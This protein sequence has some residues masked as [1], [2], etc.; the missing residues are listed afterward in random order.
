M[1]LPMGRPSAGLVALALA[2]S[3]VACDAGDLPL[4][5]FEGPTDVAILAAGSNFDVTIGFVSNARSGD[6]VKLDLTNQRWLA[7]T[8][9]GPLFRG[10]P[11]A[12]GRTRLLEQVAV[13]SNDDLPNGGG[14][15]FITLFAS[16]SI[17]Q[18]LLV[19]P[20]LD[21][22]AQVAPSTFCLN[23]PAAEP[24][25]PRQPVC[26]TY[27]SEYEVDGED[28]VAVELDTVPGSTARAWLTEIALREGRTTTEVWTVT[29]RAQFERFEVSGSLSGVQEEAAT[30]GE[31]WLAANSA[32]GFTIYQ[33]S[34]DLRDGDSFTVETDT[35]I[36]ELP[37]PGVVQDLAF[38]RASG[39][40]LATVH[41]AGAAGGALG[42]LV[43]VDAEEARVL[44]AGADIVDVPLPPGAL[45]TRMDLVDGLGEDGAGRVVYFS[46]P[47]AAGVFHRLDLTDATAA[48]LGDRW[49]VIPVGFPSV[50]V[51]MSRAPEAPWL[52]LGALQ[53]GLESY[54][55]DRDE[56]FRVRIYD[57]VA[58]AEVDPNPETPWITAE[59]CA[60]DY[61]PGACEDACLREPTDAATCQASCV[62][63][64]RARCE[65][66]GITMPSPI[67]GLA[68][69]RGSTEL[70]EE[71]NEGRPYRD[72][73]IVASTYSGSV[74]TI[75]ASRGCLTFLDPRGPYAGTTSYLP[76]G[77]GSDSALWEDPVTSRTAVGNRCGGITRSEEWTVRYDGVLGAWRVEGSRSGPQLGLAYEDRRYIS[78]GGEVSF[79]ILSG[80]A[81]ATDGDVFSI[82]MED[83]VASL[84][85]FQLPQ[86]P[87][88]YEL[89]VGEGG[90]GWYEVS[91]RQAAVVAS[92]ADDTVFTF[93]LAPGLLTDTS[94]E[95]ARLGLFQ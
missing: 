10:R 14:G 68:A 93:D 84:S 60:D 75:E 18:T 54:Q 72:H 62:T 35:G 24:L 25:I 89:L 66:E 76:I 2:A 29:W 47:G 52:Y 92:N 49:E 65:D 59:G 55:A 20:Y 42:H 4:T 86:D 17:R 61:C 94:N 83:N 82:I 74:F 9:G 56:S 39:M 95:A 38:D 50:D 3:T 81:P 31:P 64:C 63:S 70:A 69:T 40:L 51:A 77:E 80:T 11:L 28:A 43:V 91:L 12:T 88:T 16:D 57:V 90:G 30:V 27:D 19:V 21:S 1:S 58:G 33:D 26:V 7:D 41:E 8:E 78:D 79:M 53:P 48:D 15:Q 22:Q 6:I 34:G 32:L 71:D 85:G 36:V 23:D 44:G 46:D 37:M 5:S 73:L 67:E 87:A 45:P 13:Y